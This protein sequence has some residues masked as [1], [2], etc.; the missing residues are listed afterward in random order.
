MD[1]GREGSLSGQWDFSCIPF[2]PCHR[3]RINLLNTFERQKMQTELYVTWMQQ[4]F[5]AVP[6]Y[7]NICITDELP[8]YLL[9]QHFSISQDSREEAH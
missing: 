4:V 3:Q 2:F 7:S 5:L 9:L 1:M 8:S 6:E